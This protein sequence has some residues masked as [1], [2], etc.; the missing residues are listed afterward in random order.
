MLTSGEVTDTIKQE[1]GVE[2][3]GV[4]TESCESKR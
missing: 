3:S 2:E 4:S 1:S